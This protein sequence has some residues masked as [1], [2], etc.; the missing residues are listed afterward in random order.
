MALTAADVKLIINTGLSDAQVDA[1]IA[2]AAALIDPCKAKWTD[3]L[4]LEIQKYVAAHL[5][6]FRSPLLVSKKL[7]D[8][9]EV[10]QRSK[11]DSNKGLSATPYGETAL[12]LDPTGCLGEG[13]DSALFEVL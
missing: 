12:M 3:A 13:E 10:Y 7:G 11:S 9:A 2:T 5:V 4:A 8:A 1:F 6:S